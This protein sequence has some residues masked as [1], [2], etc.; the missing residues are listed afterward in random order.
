MERGLKA[1]AAVLALLVVG[2]GG[3]ALGT[4]LAHDSDGITLFGSSSGDG[5]GTIEDAY[6]TILEESADPPSEKELSRAAIKAMLDVVKKQDDYAL[7]YNQDDYQ[8]FLDY[9]TGSFSG[10]GVNLN[11]D[12]K[13]LQVLSVI[14]ATPAEA[15]GLKRGDIVYA[16]DGELVERMSI[17]EAVSK[18]KGPPGTDVTITVVRD[19]EKIDFDITRAEIAFPNLRGRLTKNDIGYIQ[20]YGFAK[21]AGRE[22]REEVEGMREKG[23]RGIVLDL[24]D[25]GGGLLSEAIEVASVF[26]EDG[27]IVTYVEPNQEDVVYEAEG[28]AFEEIPL[29]VLVNGGTASASEIVANALQDQ[30]R[31][32]LVGSTTFGKG[33]V[34]EIIDLPD[35]SAV[36]LTTGTYLSPDGEDI[37]GKGIEPDFV[38]EDNERNAQKRKAFAVLE[39]LAASQAQG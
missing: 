19:G 25:N 29:V 35:Q 39:Q 4:T 38:V 22:L 6:D 2:L 20:L 9:S 7:Y 23:A 14:P 30:D 34:Q 37:N 5:F 28:N 36:K 26:V 11:Q 27:E 1:I 3:F 15:E 8:E 18:V 31:S 33:S 17:D 21:G 32:E 24:R 13:T 12:G 16:V 10:I